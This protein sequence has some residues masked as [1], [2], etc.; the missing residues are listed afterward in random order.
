VSDK[1][2]LASNYFMSK[3]KHNFQVAAY[4]LNARCKRFIQEWLC[5]HHPD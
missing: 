5:Q 1:T 4:K 2:I 3:P